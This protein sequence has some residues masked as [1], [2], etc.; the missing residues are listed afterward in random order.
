[1]RFAFVFLPLGLV[2]DQTLIAIADDSWPTFGVLQSRTHEAWSRFFGST[3]KDDP[4]YSPERA[5]QTFPFPESWRTNPTITSAAERYYE[6]RASTLIQLDE[7]LTKVYNRF[8]NTLDTSASI[9]KLRHL[10][11]ALDRSVLDSYGWHDISEE[12]QFVPTESGDDVEYTW[13]TEVRD[14][15]LA[16]LLK[17]NAERAADEARSGMAIPPTNSD[18]DSGDDTDDAL[19]EVVSK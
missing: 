1:M 12:A 15:V 18:N 11:G 19:E 3:L 16:R 9:Q 5:F 4:R 17:L 6:H 13:P 2:Y 7:G 14:E 8:H 10:H